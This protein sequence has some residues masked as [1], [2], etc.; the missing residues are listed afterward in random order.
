MSEQKLTRDRLLEL[1]ESHY[2]YA[3]PG[4]FENIKQALVVVGSALRYL[5]NQCE[6]M[7]TVEVPDA[8][9]EDK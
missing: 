3:G 5:T 6:D 4:Q 7:E 8:G 1:I 2:Q 9:P